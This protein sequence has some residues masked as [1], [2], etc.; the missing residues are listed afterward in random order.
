MGFLSSTD[1]LKPLGIDVREKFGEEIEDEEGSY[2][3]CSDTPLTLGIGT[4]NL[5]A[6]SFRFDLGILLVYPY[7]VTAYTNDIYGLILNLRR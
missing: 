2:I 7:V 1:S 4:E 6:C 3:S 5:A